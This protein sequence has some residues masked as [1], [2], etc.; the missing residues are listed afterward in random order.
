MVRARWANTTLL[1]PGEAEP[2]WAG[3]IVLPQGSSCF[4]NHS[5][6]H[7]PPAQF[8]MIQENTCVVFLLT[9]PTRKPEVQMLPECFFSDFFW[10]VLTQVPVTALTWLMEQM[11]SALN[12]FC[13]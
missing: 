3:A 11:R 2:Q 8:H 5:Y 13:S 7:L 12:N 4:K 10:L 9:H 6:L 1:T